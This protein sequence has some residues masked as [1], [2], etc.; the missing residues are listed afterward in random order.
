M[1]HEVLTHLLRKFNFCG[2][3]IKIFSNDKQKIGSTVS[4]QCKLNGFRVISLKFGGKS[5]QIGGVWTSRTPIFR[6]Y[7]NPILI[8]TASYDERK[9][10]TFLPGHKQGD[11][12]AVHHY[13][14]FGFNNGAG[15]CGVPLNNCL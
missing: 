9:D 14:T 2:C 8:E 11:N 5:K 12:N 10:R 6:K 15:C 13:L 3:F 4:T 7:A 1:N